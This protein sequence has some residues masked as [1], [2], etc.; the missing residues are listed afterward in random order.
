MT[1]IKS[2]FK[3]IIPK[4]EIKIPNGSGSQFPVSVFVKIG[5]VLISINIG[6]EFI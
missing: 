3:N 2:P 4:C 1:P 5:A 6:R